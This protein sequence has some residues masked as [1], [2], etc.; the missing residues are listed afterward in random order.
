MAEN[1]F[2]RDMLDVK[3]L[4][5]YVMD[6]AEKPLGVQ[7]IYALCYQD[8][9]LTYFDVCEA[10]PQLVTT[11]HLSETAEGTLEITEKGR[12]NVAITGD[13]VAFPVRERAKAAVEAFNREV[14]RSGRIHTQV[15]GEEGA[16][17]ARM[18]LS[19]ET[20]TLMTM[21]LAAPGK[22]QARQLALA[23]SRCAE[24]LYGAV[25]EDLMEEIEG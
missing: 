20:G 18:E 21:E 6:L 24:R 5:L 17:R 16:Y 19:D 12:E 2:I 22:K 10:V 13:S 8:D 11:G 23:F 14:I 25:M 3:V 9:R 1:G 15:L 7:D 4:I